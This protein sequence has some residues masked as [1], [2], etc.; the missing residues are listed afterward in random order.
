[1]MK[2]LKTLAIT[3]AALSVL[4]LN[5]AETADPSLLFYLSGDSI[6]ADYSASG[7]PLPNVLDRVNSFEGGV[8]GR[9]LQAHFRNVWSYLAPGNIWSERGTVAFWWRSSDL[10]NET[11][12]P[13]LRVSFYDHTSWDM[14]WL[15]IDWN[16]HGLDAFVTDNNLARVRVSTSMERPAEDQWMH[17]AFSWDESRG[18]KLYLN[19]EK[20]AQKDSVVCLRTG[21]DQFGFHQR[22]VSPYQVQSAYIIQRGGDVDEFRIYDHALADSE[23]AS[24]RDA[25]YDRVAPDSGFDEA[26]WRR[27]LGFDKA[28]PPYLKDEVTTVRKVQ[29]DSCLD[30]KR[31]FWKACD[32]LRETTWPGVYNR[33]RLPGRHDYF[34][35]PDWDCYSFSGKTVTFVAPEDW[36]YAEITGGAYGTLKGGDAAF[37]KVK[38]SQR[39]FHM[40]DGTR[41]PCDLVFTNEVQETPIQEFNLFNVRAGEHQAA[42]VVKTLSY[43]LTDFDALSNPQLEEI[44]GFIDSR[45]REGE[46]SKLLAAGWAPGAPVSK[47]KDGSAPVAHII[48]PSDCKELDIN[49]PIEE[50][51]VV[52]AEAPE[53]RMSASA[54]IGGRF[55]TWGQLRSG[56]TPPSWDMLHAG[57]D[58]IRIS[59]PAM[60]LRP[61]KDGLCPLNIAL[62]DPISPQRYMFDFSFSVRPGEARTLYLDVRDRIL[63]Q[64]KPLYIRISGADSSFSAASLQGTRIDLI[65][66]SFND[67]LA[68]HVTDRFNQVRDNWG[69]LV[70]EGTVS[71]RHNKFRQWD[72]DLRDLLRVDPE[73]RLALQYKSFCYADTDWGYVEPEAPKGVPEWAFLQLRSLK[74][75]KHIARWYLDNRMAP[76]GEFGGG[77]CDDNTLLE[78]YPPLAA[79]GVLPSQCRNAVTLQTKA[80]YDNGM[81]TG[82]LNTIHTDAFHAYEEGALNLLLEYASDPDAPG[83]RERI[84]ETAHAI[85]DN[86]MYDDGKGHLYVASDYYGAFKI[87]REG[88]WSWGT[89]R[90]GARMM[91]IPALAAL[92][93]GDEY[94]KRAY[95]KF[96]DSVYALAVPSPDGNGL[97][98][99]SEINAYTG[100]GRLFMKLHNPV[101]GLILKKLTGSDK[102]L[103][104]FVPLPS[105][106]SSETLV[107]LYREAVKKGAQNEFYNT[108]GAPYTDRVRHPYRVIEADRLGGENVMGTYACWNLVAWQWAKETDAENVAINVSYKL[109]VD[110]SFGI[111][112][113]NTSKKPVK[114]RMIPRRAEKGTWTFNDGKKTREAVL[115]PDSGVEL[116]IPA[117]ASFFDFKKKQ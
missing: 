31:W 28:M 114:V 55:S 49:V 108:Y 26:G 105:D 22:V 10:I 71:R 97:V 75:W 80:V 65:F 90:G 29:I 107:P 42:A 63:P 44:S 41:R 106:K 27:Y 83:V 96:W 113:F 116:V 84:I 13:I 43:A 4:S 9:A 11:E 48:I 99:P 35:L 23:I 68:E 82:G 57:L 94:S 78:I 7:K 74:Q 72:G 56:I 110:D 111:E 24:V 54:E 33:S 67:A 86:Y 25:K 69:T 100:E 2:F 45:W 40:A 14:V 17:I 30:Y 19:G 21:L 104:M 109:D 37:N 47:V 60:D 89:H 46:R 101:Y 87:A 91:Q 117:G 52:S 64:D 53:R 98:A 115:T 61:G 16:G 77:L 12:F 93:Y 62:L 76:N 39:S 38:G 1:M 36:N 79:M 6:N 51:E 85:I 5:A 32:G 50:P 59:L 81:Q 58:A 66:K 92:G 88:T 102:Y 103:E 95:V 20:I 15:R 18:V 70:E 3:A 8:Y 34:E 112:F 73:N